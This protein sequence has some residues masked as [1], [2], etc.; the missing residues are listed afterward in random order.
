MDT[1]QT[2]ICRFSLFIVVIGIISQD[3]KHYNAS[4]KNNSTQSGCYFDLDHVHLLINCSPQHHI[5]DMIKALKCI[6]ARLL[7]KKN[8]ECINYRLWVD[9]YGIRVIS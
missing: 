2:E 9:I 5:P 8:G 1:S 7:M 3:V 4:F 6:S